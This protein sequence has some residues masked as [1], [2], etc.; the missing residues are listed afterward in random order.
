MITLTTLAAICLWGCL[1]LVVYAYAGYPLLLRGLSY[2]FGRSSKSRALDDAELPS[3]SLLI[4]AHNEE[5]E[6]EHRLMNALA[7]DYPREKLQIVVGS[8][9]SVDETARIVEGFA[10]RGVELFDYEQNRGKATVLNESV[11][12]LKGEIILF[13]DANTYNE[14]MSARNLVRWF[15]DPAIGVVCGRLV[16]TDPVSGRNADGLYWKYENFLKYY[17]NR[18]GALLGSNGAIYA[19]R[20]DLY[21]PIDGATIVDDFVIPLLAKVKF[22]CSI[23]YDCEAI[24][25]EETPA[26]VGAEFHRRSRIGAGGFQSIGFLWKILDPRRGWVAFS[27]LSHKIL[28][29]FCP[30]FLIGALASN[31]VLLSGGE[32]CYRYLLLAQVA[33]YLVSLLLA[34]AP[35][36]RWLRPFRLASLFSGMNLA[37]FVGFCRWL[38]GNQCGTWRRTT[39]LA[40]ERGIVR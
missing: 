10:D 8:D 37:L 9:G 13:S 24:A 6:I 14:P 20:K 27:F 36:S 11:P 32:T 23:V 16:L 15:R 3:V 1:G 39:R 4:A 12:H 29:W 17:E 33:F 40:E 2:V 21:T 26:S 38:G 25:T 31:A 28:R 34:F 35:A 7:M 22:G 19:M 5:A 18:L 30:F